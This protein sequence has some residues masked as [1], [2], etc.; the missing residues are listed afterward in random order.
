[1]LKAF[2]C[3]EKY[4]FNHCHRLV[5][6]VIIVIIW[7]FT[8]IIVAIS[9]IIVIVII[10]TWFSLIIINSSQ[11]TFVKL[12]ASSC[13]LRGSCTEQMVQIA[14]FGIE[15]PWSLQSEDLPSQTLWKVWPQLK[16][17]TGRL[18]WS[19]SALQSAASHANRVS[20]SSPF[21]AYP[22]GIKRGEVIW[23]EWKKGDYWIRIIYNKFGLCMS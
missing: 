19:S 21:H 17:C 13:T 4:L 14:L 7:V 15:N 5:I 10:R 2:L 18:T 20:G 22:K 6:I 9:I 8:V 23:L 1:M 3:F 12:L 16:R 11:Q